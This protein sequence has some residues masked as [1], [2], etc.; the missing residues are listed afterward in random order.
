MIKK[1]DG[2]S[3]ITN[4]YAAITID[5]SLPHTGWL[6]P[7]LIEEFEQV[8]DI[9]DVEYAIVISITFEDTATVNSCGRRRRKLKHRFICGRG[10]SRHGYQRQ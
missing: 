1:P 5:V 4:R 3:Y 10:H 2:T 9:R 7:P 8:C 6:R